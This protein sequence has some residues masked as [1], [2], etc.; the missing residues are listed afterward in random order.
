MFLVGHTKRVCV[1]VC[2]WVSEWLCLFFFWFCFV[3]E[4]EADW[5]LIAEPVFHLGVGVYAAEDG[6]LCPTWALFHKWSHL[7]SHSDDDLSSGSAQYLFHTFMSANAKCLPKC[8][9]G[10]AMHYDCINLW[11]NTAKNKNKTHEHFNVWESDIFKHALTHISSIPEGG[12]EWLL[13]MLEQVLDVSKAFNLE[14]LWFL[15]NDLS[16]ADRQF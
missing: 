12:V 5:V 1:C 9:V 10:L 2:V 16:E 7:R 4:P 6:M 14:D 13:V 3:G 8:H 11:K 15:L